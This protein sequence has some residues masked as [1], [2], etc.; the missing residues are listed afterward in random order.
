MIIGIEHIGIAVKDK[1]KAQLLFN[2]LLN[3]QPYK[4]EIVD[5]EGVETIFYDLQNTK[6]EL[7]CPLTDDNHITK[8]IEKRGEQVHHICFKVDDI[9]SMMENLRE[10]GFIF[11]NEK[12]KIG[13][14]NKLINFLHPTSTNGVLIELC[15]EILS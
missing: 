8:F 6:I 3:S 12:P 4:T 2:S 13:A 10:R 9:Y 14:D 1:H 7:I 5:N 15:Q 11:V